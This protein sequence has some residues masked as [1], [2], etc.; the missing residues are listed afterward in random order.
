[1]IDRLSARA[2]WEMWQDVHFPACIGR[3]FFQP[4][5][6]AWAVLRASHAMMHYMADTDIYYDMTNLKHINLSGLRFLTCRDM[7]FEHKT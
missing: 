4:M 1:M 6:C 7:C 5:D 2:S 3:G